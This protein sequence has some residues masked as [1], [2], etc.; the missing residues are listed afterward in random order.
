MLFRQSPRN[1]G[2]SRSA[3]GIM[4]GCAWIL[5]ISPRERS[6]RRPVG[7]VIPPSS[8]ARG[9][10]LFRL[11]RTGPTT[12]DRDCG[13]HEKYMNRLSRPVW[14]LGGSPGSAGRRRC[15]ILL[16]AARLTYAPNIES[17]LRRAASTARTTRERSKKKFFALVVSS[18]V[19][20]LPEPEAPWP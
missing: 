19:I 5:I 7:M 17:V 1:R 14:L 4:Y 15:R 9:A 3:A 10:V 11:S 12:T 13:S 16:F 18:K 8:R 20:T 6:H 2:A